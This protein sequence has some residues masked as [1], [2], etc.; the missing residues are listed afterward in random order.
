MKYMLRIITKE[1]KYLV[2][3]NSSSL[4]RTNLIN[5]VHSITNSEIKI[6]TK[7]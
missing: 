2:E 7:L 6:N 3:H 4:D 5:Y 1:Y